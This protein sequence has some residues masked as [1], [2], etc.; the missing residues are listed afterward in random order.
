MLEFNECEQSG[1]LVAYGDNSQNSYW[2]NEGND[3]TPHTLDVIYHDLELYHIQSMSA[4][5]EEI[6]E[7]AEIIELIFDGEI[8]AKLNPSLKLWRVE[9]GDYV[10]QG[11]S[12]GYAIQNFQRCQQELAA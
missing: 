7:T 5:I 12:L 11:T 10:T 4:D 3:K 2:I 9:F 6:K 1:Q 8:K